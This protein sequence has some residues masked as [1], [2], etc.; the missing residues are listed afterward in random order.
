MGRH[1]CSRCG[2]AL[3]EKSTYLGY[4]RGYRCVPCGKYFCQRCMRTRKALV[5]VR[6]TCPLCSRELTDMFDV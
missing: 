1:V 5:R 4:V 3:N 6:K 2:I